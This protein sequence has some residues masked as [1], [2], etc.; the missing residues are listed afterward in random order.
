MLDDLKAMAVF[1]ET[2]DAGSMS[3][4]ARRLQMTPSAVSQAIR[5]LESRGGVTLLHR[6]TRKLALT[7][8]GERYYP[9]CRRLLDAGQAAAD[10]LQ[11]ARDAPSGELRVAAPVG[12]AGHIAPA[13]APLLADAPLLRLRLL[14]DDAMIDLIEARIDI[15]VRAGRLADSGWTARRL[16]ELRTVLCAAPDYLAR[17]GTPLA[18]EELP[19]HQWLALGRAPQAGARTGPAAAPDAVAAPAASSRAVTMALDL[20][21]PDGAVHGVALQARIASNSQVALQQMCEHGLG[22]AHL[23]EADAAPALQRGA[24][25]RVLPAWRLAALPVAALTARRDGEAAKVR[26]ALDHLKRYFATLPGAAA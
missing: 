10:S 6:S 18:P 22:I 17:H 26:A 25:V 1:A 12:F 24:L 7:E 14:V 9:H 5:A 20:T 15:A 11:L 3:A 19:A 8:A 21:A 23:A 13:L 16:C 2:V 4:A